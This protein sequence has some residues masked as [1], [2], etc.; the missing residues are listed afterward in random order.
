MYSSALVI[1]ILLLYF[2]RKLLPRSSNN[3]LNHSTTERLTSKG[4]HI[5]PVPTEKNIKTDVDIIAIHGLDTKS[6]GTWTFKT[7]AGESGVNWLSNEMMLPR[8]VGSARIFTCDWPSD[9]F[10]RSGYRQKTFDEFA[11]VLFTKLAEH[12]SKD[13]ERP[14]LF[15]ASCF[16]GILLLKALVDHTPTSHSLRNAVRGIVFLATPFSGTSFRD[17]AEW[18]VPGLRAWAFIRAEKLSNLLYETELHRELAQLRSNFTA[19]CYNSDLPREHLAAFYELG[20]SSLPRKLVDQDSATLDIIETPLPLDR[21]HVLMN[22]FYC[23]SDGDYQLVAGRIRNILEKIRE[24]RPVE[25]AYAYL[26]DKCYNAENLKIERISGDRLLV[27]KCYVNLVVIKYLDE[28]ERNSQSSQ[29]SLHSRLKIETPD[30]SMQVD[31]R[32]LFDRRAVGTG[33]TIQHKRILI[34]GHAGVGK[35]TLCKKIVHDFKNHCMWRNMFVRILWIPLRNLKKLGKTNCNLEAMLREEYFSQTT[36]G[37]KFA[38]DLCKYLEENEYKE[39]L[40]ILDGLDEV[41]EGLDRDSHMFK[42]LGTLLDL[43]SVIVTSRPHASLP[44]ELRFDL[45]LETVGFYPEQVKSYMESVLADRQKVDGLQSLLQQHQLLQGLVRIPIQLDALCYIWSGDDSS[46]PQGYILRTMT[47]IYQVIVEKLWKKDVIR[48]EKENNRRAI[49]STDIRHTSLRTIE[50]YVHDELRFLEILA[51]TGMVNDAISFTTSDLRGIAS[52]ENS[53]LLFDK[54]LPRL[55]FLRTSNSFLK[56]PTYHFLHLT[57]QEYFAARYFFRQWKA[58]DSLLVKNKTSKK[59][60]MRKFLGDHKYDSRY[61]IFWR[62]VA[63]FLSLE[64]EREDKEIGRFFDLIGDQPL[65]LIGSV[66]QRLIMHCLSE[67]PPE[68]KGFSTIRKNLEDQLGRWLVLECDFMEQSRFARE[69]EIPAASLSRVLETASVGAETKSLLFRSLQSHPAIPPQVIHLACSLLQE[70]V[71]M[72]LKDAILDMLISQQGALDDEVL[73]AIVTCLEDEDESVTCLE[74]EDESVTCLEDEDE[75]VQHVA[76]SA[77]KELHPLRTRDDSLYAAAKQTVRNRMSIRRW[78]FS[79]LEKQ[80]QL[81]DKVVNALVTNLQSE[82]QL[83]DEVAQRKGSQFRYQNNLDDQ[84]KTVEI[85]IRQPQPNEVILQAIAMQL[86]NS[87]EEIRKIAVRFLKPYLSDNI[88]RIIT[89]FLKEENI[90]SAVWEAVLELLGTWPQRNGEVLEIICAQLKGHDKSYQVSGIR[91]LGKWPKIGSE[92]LDIVRARLEDYNTYAQIDTIVALGKWPKLDHQIQELVAA[93]LNDEDRDV[94]RY[95]VNTLARQ[96]QLTHNILEA[97]KAKAQDEDEDS[98]V[99]KSAMRSLMNRKQFGDNIYDMITT[100]L[101]GKKETRGCVLSALEG[102]PQPSNEIVD[103]VAAQLEED[104]GESAVVAQNK[105][106]AIYA[107]RNWYP[108]SDP[109]LEAL[110]VQ[111]NDSNAYMRSEAAWAFKMQP[112]LN[113]KTVFEAIVARLKGLSREDWERET[114]TYLLLA[115]EKWPQL[116]DDV[117]YTAAELLVFD[118]TRKGVINMLQARPQPNDDIINAIA[119]HL[120]HSSYM[121]REAAIEAMGNWSRLSDKVTFAIAA[122]LADIYS[123]TTKAVL[124]TLMNQSRLPFAAVKP[125]VELIYLFLLWKSFEEHVYWLTENGESFIVFGARKIQLEITKDDADSLHAHAAAW[126]EKF[127]FG[128]QAL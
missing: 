82:T 106:A 85:L 96:P 123:Y 92:I 47:N 49:V 119:K 127:G 37:E 68:K 38:R 19:F 87:G 26:S 107:L 108:L 11:S 31:M 91:A 81:S 124:K 45:E 53:Q 16:G 22:K 30:K 59:V 28:K 3:P 115:L 51:F 21:T 69:V 75:S 76:A 86:K 71:N 100:W 113:N 50:T 120:K 41:Y 25:A 17:V 102:W 94:R 80:S 125:H 56:D 8:E 42:L 104:S 46:L 13:K 83:R 117:L 7:K 40:V 67:V 62:F 99:R 35:T 24:G 5:E 65:D 95:A 48:L 70:N 89:P 103:L 122:C 64:D 36:R 43:P 15:I 101:Q 98:G 61:D 118:R 126:R 78:A 52:D 66:H 128:T 54:T 29:F 55:S 12:H 88:V 32:H 18:A 63:G 79:I 72:N 105:I 111:L 27:E 20:E 77:A 9:L 58:G 73:R 4:I 109:V 90:N 74:D 110:A 114:P 23:P 121:I 60:S 14:I 1:V 34:R 33:K 84:Q 44:P 10:E 6:P 93:N 39:T 57:F 2:R 97:I 112:Q 116:D